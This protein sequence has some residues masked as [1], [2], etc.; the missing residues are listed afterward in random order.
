MN[1][2]SDDLTV[3]AAA[4]LP[5]RRQP[6]PTSHDIVLAHGGGGQLT[7]D[8][9]EQTI[10]P[11]LG[12]AT[13]NQLLDSALLP[14]FGQDRPTITIDSYVVQ[15]WRFPGGDIGRLAVSGT[16]NDLAVNG[17]RAE[18]LALSLIIAEGFARA[19][20]EVVLDSI[21][22]TAAEAGVQIVTGDTKVVGR[23]Q[24]DG[25]YITTAGVGRRSREQHLGFDCVQAGDML[26]VNG[27][28]GEHGLAVMLA[29]E[30][31]HID[32]V[33]RSDAAPLN[34]LIQSCLECLGNQVAFM[35]DPTRSGLAG[36]AAD[37]AQHSGYHVTLDEARIP[38]RPEARHAADMLGLDLL[39]VANE[40]KVVFVVRPEAAAALVRHLQDLGHPRAAIIGSVGHARDGMCELLTHIGGRRIIQKP[41]G[42]QL[43]RI[44]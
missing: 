5:L 7:D 36:V 20:L 24:A 11:R 19:D 39:E 42:E 4:P 35:R 6:L 26:V 3:K 10:L 38:V 27:P 29:R 17:A 9:L 44:C 33:L 43:S 16:V 37:L 30:M 1:R 25:I 2:L 40:G 14:S 23:N 18:G 15:P 21:A 22:S 12:N 31:P 32:S 13:L 8:L 34:H 28:I 41:Y